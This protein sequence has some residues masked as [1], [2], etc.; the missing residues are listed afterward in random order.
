MIKK[1]SIIVVAV[2]IVFAAV[3]GFLFY[4]SGAKI[5][6]LRGIATPEHSIPL[7]LLNAGHIA[8]ES[9]TLAQPSNTT[10]IRE[11]EDVMAEII[12]NAKGTIDTSNWQE[13]RSEYGGFSVTALKKMTWLGCIGHGCEPQRDGEPFRYVLAND[14]GIGVAGMEINVI[15]KNYNTNLDNWID[16]YV[17]SGTSGISGVQKTKINNYD[18]LQFDI[19]IKDNDSPIFIKFATYPYGSENSRNIGG[20]DAITY[21][22]YIIDLENRYAVISYTLSI[23][24][25]APIWKMT[26]LKY[27]G[28]K[29]LDSKILSDIYATILNSFHVF[30]PTKPPQAT[31]FASTTYHNENIGVSLSYDE[32]HFGHL[33]VFTDDATPIEYSPSGGGAK[34]EIH[35]Y[36]NPTLFNNTLYDPGQDAYDNEENEGITY[37]PEENM[38]IVSYQSEKPLCPLELRT[39]QGVTYYTIASGHHAGDRYN[40][41]ISTQGIVAVVG[42]YSTISETWTPENIVF[43][44]PESVLKAGCQTVRK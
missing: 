22:Y 34:F 28:P 36:N 12:Y 20:Y 30:T 5:V 26:D 3:Q 24:D 35:L 29:A 6:V 4:K 2:L 43:D 42:G 21:R 18:A 11:I 7:S 37:A 41:Y 38:W 10:P 17:I 40:V 13:Y 8:P 44:H 16:T 1:L 27:L 25:N 15:K 39:Q 23:N 33:Q 9:I 14:D 32:S 19:H 31:T